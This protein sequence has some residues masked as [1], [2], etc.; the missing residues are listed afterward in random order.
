MRQAYADY[1]T[2]KVK[3]EEVSK[4]YIAEVADILNSAQAAVKEAEHKRYEA[5]RK[6]NE[7]YGAYQVTYTGSRA[8]DEMI[9]A[10]TNINNMA[11]GFVKKF[12]WFWFINYI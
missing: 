9:K 10:I 2:A 4:K 8:A 7:C 11:D 1:E 3:A 6:F 5:I 12:M